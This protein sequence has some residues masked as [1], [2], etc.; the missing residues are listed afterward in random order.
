MLNAE[1]YPEARAIVDRAQSYW[2]ANATYGRGGWSSMGPDLASHPD[3]AACTNA[4]RGQ[5][6]QFEF[7]RDLPERYGAYLARSFTRPGVFEIQTWTGDFL[8]QGHA[9]HTWRDRW[10]NV[11]VSG[12]ARVTDGR[13]NVLATYRFRGQGEGMC[14]SLRRVAE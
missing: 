11:M 2:K 12:L 3:Y 13:C 8:A 5:V 6:E 10:G 4:L 1:S 14:C 9:S 7:R